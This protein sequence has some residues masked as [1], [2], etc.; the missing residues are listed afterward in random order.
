M[1][2][3]DR[4]LHPIWERPWVDLSDSISMG[5]NRHLAL[6]RN[7]LATKVSESKDD[8]GMVRRR[9]NP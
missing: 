2:K 6:K 9:R 5:F 8:C 3:H 4:G 1:G 7:R